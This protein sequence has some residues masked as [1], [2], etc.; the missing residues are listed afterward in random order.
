MSN[1]HRKLGKNTEQEILKRARELELNISMLLGRPAFVLV[2]KHSESLY[3][4]FPC[5]LWFNDSINYPAFRSE[6]TDLNACQRN[7]SRASS[8]LL[9][10]DFSRILSDKESCAA[11][12][13]PMT[14]NSALGHAKLRSAREFLLPMAQ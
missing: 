5:I 11:P 6:I 7:L 9:R 8:S 13:G 1:T 10:P 14:A 3:Q 2:C 12:S 4:F